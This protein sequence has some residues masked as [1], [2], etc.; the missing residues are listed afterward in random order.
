MTI[1]QRSA[2]VRPNP[3][4][5]SGQ[6]DSPSDAPAQDADEASFADHLESAQEQ[7]DDLQI[8]AHAKQRLA[9]RNI[10]LNANERQTLTEA[11]QHL[12]EQGAQ[13]AAV[14]RDDAAFV[15]NVPNRTVVTALDQA[16]MKQRVFTQIDSAM[17]L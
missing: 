1:Q 8:S 3:G 5:Q 10:S 2:R 7:T 14:L 12:D 6:N 9:Q 11:V 4:Q 16:E 17:M 13:D 15:V